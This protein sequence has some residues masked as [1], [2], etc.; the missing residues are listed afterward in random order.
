MEMKF[1]RCQHCGQ[2]VA[3]IKETGVPIICCGDPM[4]EI[5]PGTTDAAQEKH[6]PVY[7]VE[8]DKVV[9]KVG[10]VEH[11]IRNTTFSKRQPGQVL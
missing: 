10:E 6:V 9:V 3:K 8:G 5:I 2:I 11:P 4:Q 1:F 7:T